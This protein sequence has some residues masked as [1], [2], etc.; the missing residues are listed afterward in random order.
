MAKEHALDHARQYR[1]RAEELRT[2]SD[3]WM[4]RETRRIVAR[5]ASD[6]ER[7]A[8]FLERYNHES[9]STTATHARTD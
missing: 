4:D 7:M 6:Y 3:S 1:F 5:V 8:T 2:I 9:A